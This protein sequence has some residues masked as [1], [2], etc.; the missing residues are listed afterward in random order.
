MLSKEK[1]KGIVQ[2]RRN[3]RDVRLETAL[4][5]LNVAQSEKKVSKIRRQSLSGKKSIHRQDKMLFSRQLPT[6]QQAQIKHKLDPDLQT[7]PAGSL[8]LNNL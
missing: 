3:Q 7:K 6:V 2:A 4:M 1:S 5:E 8:P